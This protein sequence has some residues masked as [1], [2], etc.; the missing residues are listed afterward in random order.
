MI[1]PSSADSGDT[2]IKIVVFQ[3]GG[4]GESKVKGIQR[5]G[6]NR[7]DITLITIDQALPPIVDDASEYLPATI[8]ADL[9]LDFL[10]HPDDLTYHESA[11]FLGFVIERY[12]WD[13]FKAIWRGGYQSIPKVLGRS[14]SELET[15]WRASL[16]AKADAASDSKP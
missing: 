6:Q 4:R 10:K 16:P 12:G 8:E 5:Y 7:F 3:Q 1:T 11:S 15:E 2:P 9:V 13:K 14:M